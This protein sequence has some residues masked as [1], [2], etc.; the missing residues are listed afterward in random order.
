MGVPPTARPPPELKLWLSP[1]LSS[2]RIACFIYLGN[3]GRG[4]LPMGDGTWGVVVG[5][6][7][8][9]PMGG[10]HVLGCGTRSLTIAWEPRLMIDAARGG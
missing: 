3:F 9:P 4:S 1:S 5:G 7:T 2:A 8:D 6:R 10:I